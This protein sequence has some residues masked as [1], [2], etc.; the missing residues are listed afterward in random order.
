MDRD[1][2]RVEFVGQSGQKKNMSKA[3]RGDAACFK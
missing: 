1:Q 2:N 3:W